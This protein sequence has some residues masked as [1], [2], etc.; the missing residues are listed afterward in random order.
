PMDTP[1]IEI[2][3]EMDV[4]AHDAPGGHCVITLNGVRVHNDQIL[5]APGEGFR[6]AQVRLAPA[7]LTHC[8]RWLGAAERCHDVARTHAARRTAFGD[9]LGA[10]QGVGFMLAD[11]EIDMHMS[12]V[13]I[14]HA[15]ALL[16][17]GEKGRH[18]SSMVKVFVSE[19]VQRIVD[20]SVQILGGLGVTGDTPVEHIFRSIRAFRIYDG[21]SETH[22]WAISRKVLPKADEVEDIVVT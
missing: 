11:N 5:G 6:Y 21:P 9:R 16:D 7:R 18:E 12:R 14:D 15:C 2:I 10:H 17:Q 8:M 19:A 20:R 1:G 4:M 13:A 22:R 3:R